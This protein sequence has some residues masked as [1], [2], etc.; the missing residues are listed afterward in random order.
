MFSSLNFFKSGFKVSD[1]F[2]RNKN[3]IKPTNDADI[4]EGNLATKEEPEIVAVS[5]FGYIIF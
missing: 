2:H 5:F 3:D 4:A 1:I